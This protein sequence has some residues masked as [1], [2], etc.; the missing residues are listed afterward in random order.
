M[1]RARRFLSTTTKLHPRSTVHERPDR[2]GWSYDFEGGYKAANKGFVYSGR[3]YKASP[4]AY[5]IKRRG[6]REGGVK[7]SRKM[8]S[9]F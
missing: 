5:K 4:L 8:V 2:S 1:Y 9:H 3:K 6:V 7:P